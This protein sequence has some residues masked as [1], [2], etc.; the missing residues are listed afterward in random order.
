MKT[1]QN[2]YNAAKV[3]F[4]IKFVELN[5]YQRKIKIN[6]FYAST[7][8]NQGKKANRIKIISRQNRKFKKIKPFL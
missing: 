4:K 7:L 3:V 1:Q 8:A 5:S 2:F 6:I